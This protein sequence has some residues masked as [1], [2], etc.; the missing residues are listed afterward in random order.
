HQRTQHTYRA[1]EARPKG[2]R[3]TATVHRLKVTLRSVKPPI[4]R[5]I[6]VASNVTLEE[7]SDLLE[8]AMGWLGGHLHA[9][10]VD[11]VTYERPDPDDGLLRG[12]NDENRH[13][14]GGVLTE[15]GAKMR[16]DYDFG[17]GWRHNVVVE[18]IEPL[19]PSVEYPRCVAGR[20]AC[21]PE[22]CGGP[23]GFHELLEAF[24]DP[25]HPRHEELTE[26]LPVNYNPEEFDPDEATDDMRAPRPFADDVW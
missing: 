17:D 4:W 3:V 16:W 7:L 9:F 26:W 6:E 15:V 5:R 23:W 10:E 22:D 8:G 21:P 18:A 24:A 20:R 11:G 25:A 1:S 19:T 13:R 14:L 12:A 2:T